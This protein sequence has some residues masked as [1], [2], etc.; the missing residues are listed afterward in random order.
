MKP[1]MAVHFS[2]LSTIKFFHPAL[3]F[4]TSF[5]VERN[6]RNTHLRNFLG[7]TRLPNTNTIH[8]LS[9]YNTSATDYNL[10]V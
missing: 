3:M 2:Q 8:D 4:K 5:N 9:N 6:S 10:L 1:K 7:E